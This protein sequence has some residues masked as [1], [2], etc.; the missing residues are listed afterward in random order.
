MN[1]AE[2]QI[3]RSIIRNIGLA[4]NACHNTVT[5]DDPSVEP[6]D[7]SWR[8]DN[9]K[10]IDQLETLAEMLGVNTDTDL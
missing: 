8:I 6:D 4:L 7:T 2:R 5:T 1:E 9:S 10:E 3:T